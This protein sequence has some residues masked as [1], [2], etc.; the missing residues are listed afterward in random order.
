MTTGQWLEDAVG[1]AE[2]SIEQLVTDFRR[3]PFEHRVEHSFHIQLWNL[4]NGHETLRR[5]VKLVDWPYMTQLIHKEWPSDRKINLSG[6]GNETRQRYD[7]AILDP[8]VLAATK[9]GDFV[10]GVPSAAIVIELGL[11]YSLKHLKQDFEK[12]ELNEAR[13]AYV[14]HFSRKPTRQASKVEE[15]IEEK[16][17]GKIRTAYVH[18][19]VKHDAFKFKT[20][21]GRTFEEGKYALS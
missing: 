2:E 4:L 21:D 14:V 1:A 19:D 12:L 10:N 8:E 17:S 15:L 7:I 18:L 13:H 9:M 5:Q 20:L 3:H 16:A 6:K 11:D